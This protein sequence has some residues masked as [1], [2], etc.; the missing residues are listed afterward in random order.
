MAKPRSFTLE[1]SEAA[2]VDLRARLSRTRFP[3]EAPGAGWAHGT[4]LAYA[5]DLIR[6]WAH[7][8]D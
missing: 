1:T 6:Y 3:D 8:F 4:S 2:L 7:D 5:K